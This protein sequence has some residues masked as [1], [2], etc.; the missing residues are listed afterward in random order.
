MQP[1]TTSDPAPTAP[2]PSPVR[3]WVPAP[4]TAPLEVEEAR[5]PVRPGV[6]RRNVLLIIAG[7]VG[8]LLLIPPGH[9]YPIIDDWIY[10]GSVQNQLTT[11]AFSMPPQSQANLAGLTLWGTLWARVFGLSYTTLTAATLALGLVGLLAFYGLARRVDVPP[12]GALL[13]TALLGFNP[14]FLHL[15]YSF[16]TDVPFLALVLVAC[17]GYVRGLQAPAGARGLVWLWEAGL[18]IGWAFLIRQF[19]LLAPLAFGGVLL[20]N[21]LWTRRW[22]WRELLLIVLVPGLIMGAWTFYTRDWPP[23]PTSA[24]AMARAQVYVFKEP[25]LRVFLLRAFTILPVT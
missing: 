11:G 7:F 9:E 18:F 23:T 13:G 3:P 16:M 4:D 25:W 12:A 14:L 17:Y 8:V 21:G 6:D 5:A 19:A 20:L 2:R 22:R 10:A 1:P 15:S 24:A